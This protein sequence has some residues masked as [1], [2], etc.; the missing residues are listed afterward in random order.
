MLMIDLSISRYML[1]WMCRH[2]YIYLQ[3]LTHNPI[4]LSPSIYASVVMPLDRIPFTRKQ[5]K[6]ASPAG[7]TVR[8]HWTPALSPLVVCDPAAVLSSSTVMA[9]G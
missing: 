2:I 4:T 5:N 8:H 6:H 9:A 3:I 7:G 1:K